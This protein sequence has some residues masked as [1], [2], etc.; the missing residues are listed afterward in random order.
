MMADTQQGGE[1]PQDEEV[2]LFMEIL[3]KEM[4]D[5]FELNP[6]EK[7]DFEPFIVVDSREPMPMVTELRNLGAHVII[8]TLDAGDYLLSSATGVE[9][10][11]G[12]DFYSSLTSGSNQTNVFQ[13]LMRLRD[14]VEKPMLVLEDFRKMFR[15]PEQMLS[16][17]YGALVFIATRMVIPILPTR[18][19]AET[20]LALYRIAKQQQCNLQMQAIARRAP[21][22]MS[23]KE[24]QAFFI[25]GL[26]NVG[27]TKA[28]KILEEFKSPMNFIK[29]LMNTE[30]LYTKTG[31]PKGIDGDLKKLKGF[32]WKFVKENKDL[33][34][35]EDEDE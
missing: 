28:A 24:R 9:R 15:G 16:S 32:G 10:K 23:T 2:D 17:L 20:A 19:K 4:G 5:D 7:K 13:E 33:L 34:L 26:L 6:D 12:S 25:E 35:S 22:T 11:E 3:R 27:P 21:K 18:N 31:N 30:I 14:S 1:N 29:A 8:T